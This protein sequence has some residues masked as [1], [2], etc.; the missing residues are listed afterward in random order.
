MA[1]EISDAVCEWCAKSID[2]GSDIAC[3]KCYSKAEADLSDALA[4][5]EKL[6]ERIAELKEAG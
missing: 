3:G 5:I 6:K 2:D 4:E 1:Y